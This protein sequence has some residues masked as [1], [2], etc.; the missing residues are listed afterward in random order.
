M[1]IWRMPPRPRDPST[2]TVYLDQSTLCDAYRACMS[3][4]SALATYKPLKG[5]IERVAREANLCLS[6]AHIVEISRIPSQHTVQAEQIAAWIDSMPTLWMRSIND[7]EPEEGDYWT[8]IAAGITPAHEVDVFAA[9]ISEAFAM[10]DAA[11]MREAASMPGS[12]CP[13]LDAARE[14]GF[15][16]QR[17]DMLK[18]VEAFRVNYEQVTA[19]GWTKEQKRQ[20]RESKQRV[21]IRTIALEAVER[22]N[23][24]GDADLGTTP[25]LRSQVMNPLVKLVEINLKALPSWRVRQAH[26]MGIAERYRTL[27]RT[28]KR[29]DDVRGDWLD[30]Q[31][32]AVA[33]AHCDV[34]TCDGRVAASIR[35]ARVGLGLAPPLTPKHHR[36]GVAGFVSELMGEWPGPPRQPRH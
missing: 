24:N 27:P 5:W 35:D 36:G 10:M 8:K 4:P 13:Y 15:A 7:I 34:F 18:M 22:M 25:L 9:D 28:K 1:A 30:Y 21:D 17:D 29:E 11:A 23:R 3:P 12:I 16:E 32:V 31:H 14:Y 33:A 20:D 6:T 19:L 26:S 2:K